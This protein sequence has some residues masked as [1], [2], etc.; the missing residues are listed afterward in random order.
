VPVIR[1]TTEDDWQLLR[2]IRL[3]ALEDSPDA[4]TSGHGDEAGHDEQQWRDWLR[5]DMWF[6]AFADGASPA[7]VGVVAATREPSPPAGEYFISSLW[8]DPRHRRR[9]IARDLIQAAADRV[10]STGATVVSL[11]VLDGNKAARQFY[12]AVGFVDAGPRKL[13]PGSWHVH[14]NRMR[15]RV[16]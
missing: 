8:V 11:W 12:L 16:P 14:E 7:P 2:M 9:G 10:A 15:R 6:L 1:D 5:S 3:A 13:A 4:F